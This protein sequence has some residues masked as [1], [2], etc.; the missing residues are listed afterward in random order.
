MSGNQSTMIEP[1]RQNR[2]LRPRALMGLLAVFIASVLLNRTVDPD[3]QVGAAPA[4]LN[5]PDLFM[6][7]ASISQI[8]EEGNLTSKISADRFTHYPLTDVTTLELPRVA[9]YTPNL[10]GPWTIS[11]T[12]GRL[13]GVSVY[14]K[15]SVELWSTVRAEKS[16]LDGS[17]TTFITDTLNVYPSENLAESDTAVTIF[18]ANTQTKAARLR[19][20]FDQDTFLFNSNA[21]QRV[22]TTI[23]F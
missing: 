15:Q 22:V 3:Q 12:K 19:V 2:T 6:T 18:T 10:T 20:N 17:K 23:Q 4:R 7:Q 14:R 21:T 16:N 9:L 1:L 13:L 8:N 5:E 11:S